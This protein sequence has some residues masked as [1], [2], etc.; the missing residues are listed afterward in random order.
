MAD[1]GQA[2]TALWP[3]GA[4][5]V[6]GKNVVPPVLGTLHRAGCGSGR[7]TLPA[8]DSAVRL[9]RAWEKQGTPREAQPKGVAARL[10]LG[11]TAG[12]AIGNRNVGL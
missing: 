10:C 5:R 2:A 4:S 8:S 12:L 6:G 11:Y 1:C 9:A 3:R 7:A